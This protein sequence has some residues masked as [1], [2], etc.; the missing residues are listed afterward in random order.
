M[1]CAR[2]GC[3]WHGGGHNPSTWASS[4]SV[5]CWASARETKKTSPHRHTLFSLYVTLCA[6]WRASCA[7]ASIEARILCNHNE[8][9]H[10]KFQMAWPGRN[11]TQI[12]HLNSCSYTVTYVYIYVHTYIHTCIHIYKYINIYTS[13][14]KYTQYFTCMHNTRQRD[15]VVLLCNLYIYICVCVY[16]YI[17]IYIY[18]YMYVY[19]CIYICICIWIYMY[20]ICIT[21]PRLHGESESG[22]EKSNQSWRLK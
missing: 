9:F 14:Y 4:L 7:F 21:R 11:T 6:G 13:I 10:G 3:D 22:M 8:V 19:V 1:L 5:T 15:W 16:I 17:Y 20:I 2:S 18:I 12:S